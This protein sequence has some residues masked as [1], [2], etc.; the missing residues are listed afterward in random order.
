MFGR[1]TGVNPAAARRN[2]TAG[3][4]L[5]RSGIGPAGAGRP[6]LT[7]TRADRKLTGIMRIGVVTTVATADL[8]RAARLGLGS[9][10]WV[11]F[12]DGGAGPAHQ[13]WKPFAEEVAAQAKA[14]KLRISA[15]GAFY[16]N[17]LDP[18]QTEDAK[19]VMRRAIEVAEHIGVR[20]V[21]A[22]AG[23]VVRTK[24]NERGGNPVYEPFENH[25]G[26][27]LAFWEPQAKLAADH[28][29]R[30][31]FE[32][33][34]QAPWRLPMMGYN[35][36]DRPAVWEKLFD[37]TRCENI[38]IEWDP[39][40]LICQMIDPVLNVQR[41]GSRIFHVHAKDARIDRN[42][43]ALYGPCHAGVLEHRFP[44]LG[45]ANWGEII[46]ELLRAG[47]DSDLNIEGWHDSVY[48]DHPPAD[49]GTEDRL[50]GR[51][52]EDTGLLLAKKTL[53]V[54]VPPEET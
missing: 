16:R 6:A 40:H 31:A 32:H 48:R 13:E 25:L 53:E 5:R 45:E 49:E 34:P 47:Y 10:E 54:F 2:G 23:A 41:F 29:V 9:V 8:D 3:L 30:L 24:I 1:G 44:G 21:S 26:E 4:G 27:L 17:A 42:L 7:G 14:R 50:A 11:R 37:A 12:A 18:R 38:G 22:F 33:C 52:L 51:R 20:T 15:I 43:L 46:R 35:T 36:L 19:A 28:G 39:S